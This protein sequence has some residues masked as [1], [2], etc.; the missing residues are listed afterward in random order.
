MILNGY[1]I[2]APEGME[3]YVEGK[4]IKFKPAVKKQSY[5]D[6]AVALFKGKRAYY[7]DVDGKISNDRLETRTSLVEPNNCTSLKQC[8]KLLAYNKLMNVAK[9]LNGGETVEYGY[10]ICMHENAVTEDVSIGVASDTI[11]CIRKGCINF[12]T[13]ELARQAIEIL[14][15]DTIKLALSTDW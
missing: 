11:G 9:Y 14:G 1:E 15:E 4:E 12:E 8:Q 3:P 2:I 5:D 7:V 6:I 10:Y 13:E